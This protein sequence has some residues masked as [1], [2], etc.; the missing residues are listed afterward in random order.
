MNLTPDDL[1]RQVL[2]SVGRILDRHCDP[3][4]VRGLVERG[5]H[6]D[7][8]Y[9]DL[10]EAGFLDLATAGAGPLEAALVG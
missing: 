1:Q 3:Q 8:L 6:D 2:D 4:R 5:E 10:A 9:A 7:A